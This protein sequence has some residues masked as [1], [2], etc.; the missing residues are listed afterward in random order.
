MP[1]VTGYRGWMAFILSKSY[2][3]WPVIPCLKALR[4][5]RFYC[6]WRVSI[7]KGSSLETHSFRNAPG[8]HRATEAQ[9]EALQKAAHLCL[10]RR[11]QQSLPTLSEGSAHGIQ[12]HVAGSLLM[13]IRVTPPFFWNLYRTT[14]CSARVAAWT[15]TLPAAGFSD[16]RHAYSAR[17]AEPA[18]RHSTPYPPIIC[19]PWESDSPPMTSRHRFGTTPPHHPLLIAG[20][21][22]VGGL[23]P[24]GAVL[25]PASCHTP[26]VDPC[27]IDELRP[28][29]TIME[30][31][32]VW[33]RGRILP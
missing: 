21:G 13:H 25:G 22:V 33:I 8:C 6:L 4:R 23:R 1:G 2:L 29:R 5:L 16:A 7:P 20:D 15:R 26:C 27:F 10:E 17:R 14:F 9:M 32:A 18:R 31:V 30:G 28:S 11:S 24:R 19:H 12:N 3:C